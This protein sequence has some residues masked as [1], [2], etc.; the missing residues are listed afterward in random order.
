[1]QEIYRKLF[2]ADAIVLASPS[3][4]GSVTAQ[5]KTFMDRTWP[6]RNGRLKDKIGG[7]IAVGRRYIENTLVTLNTFLLR[8]RLII[9]HRG[10]LG[11]AF[12]KGEIIKD[13]EA[14]KMAHELG[15]RM[16][17]LLQKFNRKSKGFKKP[18]K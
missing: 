6:L 17:E 1:M 4:F 3:Y 10:V 13:L 5:M 11:Y 9:G 18:K 14:I 12:E 8:H 7:S 2:E 15:E 16:L